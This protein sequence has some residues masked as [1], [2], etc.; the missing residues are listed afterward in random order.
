M[1]PSPT[2]VS[3]SVLGSLA[4]LL[5][6]SVAF[7]ACGGGDDKPPP[8]TT[9]GTTTSTSTTSTGEGGS[10]AG[11]GGNTGG[12]GGMVGEGGAGGNGGSGGTPPPVSCT[13]G[14][15]DGSET[16][17]DCGGACPSCADGATCSVAGDCVSRRCQGSVCVAASCTNGTQDG[18]E[19]DVD[20]GGGTMTTGSNP[21]CPPCPLTAG[22]SVREDCETLNCG[23]TNVCLAESCNDGSQNQ[24]ETDMDC[25]GPCPACAA[26]SACVIPADCMDQVCTTG[27]CMPHTCNDGVKNGMESDID[28]GSAC[29]SKCPPGQKCSVNADCSTGAC[30][31]QGLCACPTGML[32]S[33]VI[34]GGAYCIDQYEVTK[35]EYNIFLQANPNMAGLPTICAGNVYQPS[36]EW[37]PVDT[38]TPVTAIDWCDAYTYCKYAG[39]HLCGRIG[40]GTNPPGSHANA[41]QSE[42]FSACS[43]QGVS[44]YP[45]GNTYSA[46]MCNGGSNGTTLQRKRENPVPPEV[47][48][49]PFPTCNG[50]VSTLYQMSGNASEWEDSCNATMTSCRV[51][52][53]SVNTTSEDQ[54]RCDADL[55]DDPLDNSDVYRGFRCCL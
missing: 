39:K 2:I 27:V 28:C 46:G 52:G 12:A 20:C 1:K 26:G 3:R 45:Y 49:P 22:C 54:I 30:T 16:D 5:F 17:L 53:G 31:P 13:N 9:S 41:S 32:V 10:G 23:S 37:P 38:R 15:M 34:G 55:M 24:D 6:A 40:G 18:S 43:G 21:A 33:P 29:G 50:A 36:A 8:R 44:A 51:R 11:G 47:D 7:G 14:T 35:K 48:L 25:G 42:W 4:G 19:T